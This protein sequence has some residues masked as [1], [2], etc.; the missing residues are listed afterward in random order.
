MKRRYVVLVVV[1]VYSNLTWRRCGK[2]YGA[3]SSVE[4][5][6]AGL[7][8]DPGNGRARACVAQVRPETPWACKRGAVVLVG[9]KNWKLGLRSTAR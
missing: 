7:S 9:L 4:R 6:T 5:W 3:V 8:V 2:Q 1:V